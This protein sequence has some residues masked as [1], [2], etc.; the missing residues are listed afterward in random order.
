[1]AQPVVSQGGGRV[2]SRDQRG[3]DQLTVR[4]VATSQRL[5]SFDVRFM[6]TEAPVWE[7]SNRSFV[8]IAS[9]GGLGDRETLVRCRLSG[10]CQRISKITPRDTLSLPAV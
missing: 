9:V 6:S 8:F 4:N 5:A 7:S 1:M 2:V 10:S 3:G